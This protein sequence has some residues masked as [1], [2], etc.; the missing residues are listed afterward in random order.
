[1]EFS[2]EEAENLSSFARFSPLHIQS[3]ISLDPSGIH[4]K[5]V[6]LASAHSE[7]LSELSA[8]SSTPEAT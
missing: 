2:I 1:M 6:D 4:R 8:E 7:Q 3:W 5:Q